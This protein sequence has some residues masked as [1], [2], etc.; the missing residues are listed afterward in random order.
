MRRSF[1]G[2]L[3]CIALPVTLLA[4]PPHSPSSL[5]YTANLGQW[6]ADFAYKASSNG[7]TVFINNNSFTYLL[8]AP[9]NGRQIHDYKHNQT[10][11]KP[12]LSYYA[13]R[14]TFEN[15]QA[16]NI[17][18][19]KLAKHYYN[20]F[21]GNQATWRSNI[22]PAGNIKLKSLYS[23][24]DVA[25]SSASGH[26]KY[27]LLVAPGV[28]P[29][30]IRMRYD[31]A[32]KLS[33]KRGRLL[34]ATSLGTVVEEAPFAYQYSAEGERKEVPC[35]YVLSGTVVTFSFPEDYDHSLPLII[36]PTVVF[37][38]YSGSFA[39]NWGFTATYD[40]GGNFYA[41][42]IVN[43]TPTSGYPTTLGA[44]Q[45]VYGGGGTGGGNGNAMPC[46][47]AI[48]K[49]NPNGT[50]QVWSTYLGGS[51]N[52]QPHSMVVDNQGNLIISGR[53]YSTNYPT[54]AGCFSASLSGGADIVV[55]KL[56]PTGST[57]LGSTYVGGSSDDGVNISSLYGNHTSL[58]KNYGDDARSEVITDAI[59]DVYVAASTQSS[60]FPVTPTAFQSTQQGVQDGV[61]FKLS[62]NFTALTWST[63]LGG[64]DNDAAYVLALGDNDATVYV[65]GGTASSNFPST[66]GTF[67]PSYMG[68]A[69][70]GFILKFQNSGNYILLKGTFLG[71]S[72]YDQAYGIQRDI[73]NNIYSMGQTV[74]G[75]FPV[76]PGVFSVPNSSQF[77]IKLDSNLTTN[78]F[79]TVWGS[80]NALSPNISPVA[81]LVDT[82]EQMYISGWGGPLSS[83]GG[84]TNGLPITA[85]AAQSTTDG[86]DFYFI[87]LSKNA[88]SL[89]YG[90]YVG[91]P[92]LG[93][94]VDGGT[95]RFNK[96][97][98]IYQAIC[99]GCGGSSTFPTTPSAWSQVN[100]SFNCNLVSLK[101]AFEFV[102]GAE[103][104]VA[105]DSSGCAPFTAQFS[106][107]SVYAESYLWD[108]GDGT[109]DTSANP[110]PHTYTQS[111]VYKVKLIANNVNACNTNSDTSFLTIIVD[112]NS[113]NAA[114]TFTPPDTCTQF[115]VDF[116]NTSTE[117][118]L[119]GAAAV[120][121]YE[122]KF[123]DGTTS[124][125]KNPGTHIY[126]GSGTYTITLI[127][128]DDSACVTIDSVQATISLQNV[129]VNAAFTGPDSIC[130]NERAVFGNASSNATGLQYLFGDGNTSSAASPIYT[131]STP[132]T[133][134]VMMI[135]SN[136]GSCN[137]AD[138][139]VKTIRIKALPVA[140]FDFSP[141]VP[142]ANE[143]IVFTDKSARAVKWAWNFGDFSGSAAQNPTHN[144]KKT[145]T[146]NVCLS[147]ESI[148]GCID[149]VC[150]IVSAD[151]SPA[152]DVPTGFT[153]NDDGKND[154]LYVRGAAVT[155]VLF[156]VY[157]RWGQ[158]VFETDKMEVG[159]DGRFNGKPQEMESYGWTLSASFLDGSSVAKSGNVTLMR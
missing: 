50:A 64:S 92:V 62:P 72:D 35:D 20:Y 60:D 51:D 42:G 74:G 75:T 31:G 30:V 146:Y 84:N 94:H 22:H 87:V 40:A 39:D 71:E 112:T 73:N 110:P 34:V 95:S 21:L 7:T 16:K 89:L 11:Q 25:L 9:D 54:T 118:L 3:W 147:V 134:Q 29:D 83:N 121:T 93:E 82:C 86:S 14:V 158:L 78:I 104:H 59:G 81:F 23:G 120:T 79:S 119:P 129:L 153:P 48:T 135:A 136:P 132:G 4:A 46:D 80:G 122:W 102:L 76:T 61:L 155:S 88:Q 91:S 139:A 150:K 125:V 36:D 56:D 63:Y 137:G 127:M 145:G 157:N 67:M 38:T 26:M 32:T 140:D 144:Y 28:S 131:Y 154:V 117:S 17:E 103:A 96:D 65:A 66:P 5:E 116:V 8:E 99:G 101:I 77:V 37:A 151:V 109:T 18:A 115:D 107:S 149:T 106:N 124:N 6:N 55:S 13:Y 57:L 148:D 12:V 47:M 100:N 49:Y 68:G 45:T 43:A 15:G 70:D 128:R 156:R 152:I 58:K 126:P 69:A 130:L 114:F 133:Y 10:Q 105:P 142:I 123:G 44:W 33:M 2:L 27:D 53:T 111:G 159:W 19:S 98:E 90:T 24:I 143:P 85:N 97:G 1:F 108:F 113:I 141:Q 52:E 41:G 138:T